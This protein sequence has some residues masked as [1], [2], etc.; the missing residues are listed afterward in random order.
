MVGRN[1]LGWLGPLFSLALFVGAL[2][3]LV[4]GAVWL[5]RRIRPQ[6]AA[7]GAPRS[8]PLDLARRRLAS[9]EITLE[10]FQEIRQ[11]LD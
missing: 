1:G 11:H 8:K 9:G 6:P 7:A 3:L 10:E 2:A 5:A 4:V